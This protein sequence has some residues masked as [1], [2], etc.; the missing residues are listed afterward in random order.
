MGAGSA[1]EA[2]HATSSGPRTAARTLAEVRA[3]SRAS[4]RKLP[5]MLALL[6]SLCVFHRPCHPDCRS[7][8]VARALARQFPALVGGSWASGQPRMDL[9]L[10]RQHPKRAGMQ[11][12]LLQV[13]V[14]LLQVP[15]SGAWKLL[16]FDIASH[17]GP[18]LPPDRNLLLAVGMFW[19]VPA[20][21]PGAHSNISSR[22]RA[23][24]AYRR[25][26]RRRA[27]CFGSQ[28]SSSAA[29]RCSRGATACCNASSLA[30][31]RCTW[32]SPT[33]AGTRCTSFRG[34]AAS[35]PPWSRYC[36]R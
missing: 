6:S 25:L 19:R 20:S 15:T 33:A 2:G 18:C 5:L 23:C 12:A 32:S 35:G 8:P 17:S 21:T 7:Q 36:T 14:Q 4:L 31:R 10:K 22:P 26:W 28:M 27:S 29:T 1:N 16:K 11:L 3:A 9:T 13:D 30:W 34:T 24:Q